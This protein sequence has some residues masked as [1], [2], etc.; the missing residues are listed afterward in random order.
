MSIPES[1]SLALILNLTEFVF[2]K[3]KVNSSKTGG[4]VSMLNLYREI[5]LSPDSPIN[6]TLKYNVSSGIFLSSFLVIGGEY[7]TVG[8]ALGSLPYKSLTSVT[9]SGTFHSKIGLLLLYH[10]VWLGW[11]G[12]KI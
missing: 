2:I 12:E 4:F 1:S 9:P 5:L 6:W 11:V 3:F 10:F 7:L 8:I